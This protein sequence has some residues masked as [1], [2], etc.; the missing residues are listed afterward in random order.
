MPKIISIPTI[1]TGV[2]VISIILAAYGFTLFS[3]E[4][5]SP[6]VIVIMVDDLEKD[7]FQLNNMYN[8]I[9]QECRQQI[10]LLE[11]IVHK[12]ANCSGTTCQDLENTNLSKMEG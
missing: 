9:P 2:F 8:C 7:P 1:V 12:L 10:E 11:E 4:K 6:N 3:N 5:P